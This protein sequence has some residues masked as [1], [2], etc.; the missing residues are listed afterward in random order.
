MSGN[1][2]STGSVRVN[3]V[4]NYTHPK[5]MARSGTEV[6][7]RAAP[8]EPSSASTRGDRPVSP[9][10]ASKSDRQLIVNADDEC[11]VFSG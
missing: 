11:H 7:G 5:D 1:L 9:S 2:K 6:P 3:T 8:A 4:V 10:C